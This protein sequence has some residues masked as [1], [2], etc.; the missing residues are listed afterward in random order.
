MVKIEF[1]FDCFF[2][3]LFIEISVKWILTNYYNF[4]SIAINMLQLVNNFSTYRRLKKNK[5][6]WLAQK[7]KKK[8]KKRIRKSKYI[9][10][11]KI[12]LINNHGY[13]MK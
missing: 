1:S 3:F 7:K 12:T 11:P 5:L 6:E 8:K 10:S 2:F 4:L 9:L 13:S